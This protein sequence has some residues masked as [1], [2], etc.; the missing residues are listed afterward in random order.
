MAS[1]GLQCTS[2]LFSYQE[3][4]TLLGD[5]EGRFPKAIRPKQLRALA[6]MR[7]GRLTDAQDDLGELY[8]QGVRD[9]ETLGSYARTW[10][11]RY[12]QSGDESDLRPRGTG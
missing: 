10:Q 4:E 12:A 3:A 7:R 1:G 2:A 9:A 11:N 6:L 5:M 8:E